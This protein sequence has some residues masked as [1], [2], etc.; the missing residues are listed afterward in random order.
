[1]SMETP[2]TSSGPIPGAYNDGTKVIPIY[3]PTSGGVGQVALEGIVV[4]L[5]DGDSMEITMKSTADEQ[6]IASFDSSNDGAIPDIVFPPGAAVFLKFAGNGDSVSGTGFI[7]QAKIHPSYNARASNISCEDL[8]PYE[9]NKAASGIVSDGVFGYAPGKHCTATIDYVP[10]TVPSIKFLE[11]DLGEG[12]SL[13]LYDGDSRLSGK[14]ITFTQQNPPSLS[15][16]YHPAGASFIEFSSNDDG[17]VGSG[18]KIQYE[19]TPI[20]H[21]EASRGD[22]GGNVVSNQNVGKG[23]GHGNGN[24]YYAAEAEELDGSLAVEAGAGCEFVEAEFDC[25]E[26]LCD[27]FAA[28]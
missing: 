27:E 19:F 13:T 6:H 21:S 15:E 22:F 26:E 1:M 28:L 3:P 10:N 9:S 16:T 14:S 4:D 5:A 20:T 17:S 18:Y 25:A 23:V 2:I 11:F 8:P 12:D 24:G 7:G